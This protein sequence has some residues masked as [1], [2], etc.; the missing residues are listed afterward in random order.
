MKINLIILVF[1]LV[2]CS[3]SNDDI[4]VNPNPKPKY[5]IMLDIA[6]T[7]IRNFEVYAGS[8]EGLKNKT[9]DF[10]PREI[11][12]SRVDISPKSLVIQNDSILMIDGVHR[13]VYKMR[14][15]SVFVQNSDRTWRNIG[16][17]Q[18]D[19]F[20]YHIALVYTFQSNEGF[21][22]IMVENSSY[23]LTYNNFFTVYPSISL[24]SLNESKSLI[25]WCN[26]YS[27]YKRANKSNSL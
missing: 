1:L 24:N 16:Y 3:S 12:D 11:W 13:S 7:E 19:D 8:L 6:K 4:F 23:Y 22:N 25:A 10:T 9:A 26:I 5:P 17:C 18:G 20:I 2:S 27:R 14:A 15:D 21:Q